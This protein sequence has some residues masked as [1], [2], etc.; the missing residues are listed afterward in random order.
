M[1]LR[2]PA[3][4]CVSSPETSLSSLIH[5]SLQKYSDFYSDYKVIQKYNPLEIADL[6]SDPNKS[7][8]IDR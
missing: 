8:N 4:A 3:Q 2:L 1:A 5:W 6:H 7:K